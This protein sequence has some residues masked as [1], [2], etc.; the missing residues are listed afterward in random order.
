MPVEKTTNKQLEANKVDY[1]EGEFPEHELS[2]QKPETEKL[3]KIHHLELGDLANSLVQ[4]STSSNSSQNDSSSKNSKTSNAAGNSQATQS[5]RQDPVELFSKMISI[6]FTPPRENLTKY[7]RFL[8]LPDDM[9]DKWFVI[10]LKKLL[11]KQ[12]YRKIN[13]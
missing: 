1:Y 6:G 5:S 13:R 3:E 7:S 12:R 9:S 2:Y 11:R 10:F 4:S 8:G